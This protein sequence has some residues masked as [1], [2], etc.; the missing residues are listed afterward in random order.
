MNAILV[1]LSAAGLCMVWLIASLALLP[2]AIAGAVIQRVIAL[3][4]WVRDGGRA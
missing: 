1:L 3:L 4:T 2:F